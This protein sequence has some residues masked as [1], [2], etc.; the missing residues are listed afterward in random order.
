M[1][2]KEFT[3]NMPKGS[4]WDRIGIVT[5]NGNKTYKVFSKLDNDYFSLKVVLE[6]NQT[7]VKANY[8]LS[9]KCD[10]CFMCVSHDF[11]R[12]VELD[13]EL[14]KNVRRMLFELSTQRLENN[15]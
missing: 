7:A 10:E 8:H 5:G 2:R 12:L 3:G 9:I 14:F 11:K 1:K 4:E 13:T 6:P 15:R